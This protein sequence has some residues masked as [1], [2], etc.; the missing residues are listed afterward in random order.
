MKILSPL[1]LIS[2]VLSAASLNLPAQA[3]T[4]D[5][6]PITSVPYT[7][8]TQ[9][10]YCLTGNLATSMTSGYAIDI[11]TNNVT[12]DLN[13]YK[14]GGLAAGLGTAAYGIHAGTSPGK[15]N[16]TIKNGT[17]RGF[18]YGIVISG[19]GAVVQD[20]RADGNTEYGIWVANGT[21][22][23]I[24]RNV[25]INTGGSTI[26]STGNA[27]GI[28]SA[29]QNS[30]VM[31]NLVSRLMPTGA[32]NAYGIALT[33]GGGDGS[34]VDGNIVS[35]ISKPAGGGASY[36]IYV[37]GVN[38]SGTIFRSEDIAVTNNKVAFMNY[39]I[40][41]NT[42]A[43]GIYANNLAMRCDTPFTGGTGAGTT[44]YSN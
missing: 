17:I 22:A 16:I 13:G 35:E 36:G 4:V 14:L 9:G 5:C 39:G 10:I 37:A 42:Y 31:D 24:Q 21:G 23:L 1:F 28:F 3:E 25:V 18:R 34:V 7:V 44:N 8:T 38:L 33:G 26:S 20:I 41:Y 40:Y 11:E 43:S 15:E 19:S 29:V 30:K 27:Y 2:S 6:I 32:G 12:L